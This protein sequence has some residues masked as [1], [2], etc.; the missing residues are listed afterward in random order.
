[1]GPIPEVM[2]ASGFRLRASGL[3]FAAIVALVVSASTVAL[4]QGSSDEPDLAMY[5]RIRDEGMSRSRVMDYAFELMDRIGARLSGSPN[6][7]RAVAWAVDRM[8]QAGLENVR[9]DRWGEFGM[10]WR[11]RGTSVVLI[12]PDSASLPAIAAPW[13]PPTRGPVTGEV[14]YVRGFTDESGFAPLRGTLEGKVVM[15]GR[16]PSLPEV[17]PIDRPLFERFTAAQ[18]AELAQPAAAAPQNDAALEKAFADAAFYE[19][20]SRFFAEEGVRAV[21]TPTGNNARGGLSGGVLGADWNYSLGM[22]AHRREHAMQVP[23]AVV[24]IEAFGRVS[25]L[26]ERKSRVRVTVNVDTEVTGDRVDGVNVFGEIP[27]VDAGRGGDVVMVG[28]HLDSWDVGTGATDDGAGVIIALEA[29][30]ILRALDVRPRRTIRLA[31]WTGEEQGL[32]GSFAW[33]TREI[34]ALPRVDT[35]AQRLRPEAVRRAAGPPAT[36]PAHARLSAYY[37][38]DQGGGKIRGVRLAGNVAMAPIFE[39]WI[40]PLKEL[41]VAVVSPRGGCASDCASFEE[42][43]IP[44]PLFLQDPLDYPS[45]TLHTSADTADHLIP[46]D[47]RQAAVVVATMLYNT[48]MRDD[49][50]PR[51]TR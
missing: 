16:A 9:R 3:V 51:A 13:S 35:P 50:L 39:R 11:Q 36:K 19:R 28:A 40:A 26:L 6:L 41:G 8:G 38:L 17:T 48:A 25:R 24:S 23:V 14:V 5:A 30:R 32:Q 22:R 46:E 43:G 2:M 15:L 4:G 12:E 33:V 18:L 21:L 37:N 20:V 42:A 44:T 49:L 47:L 1:M 34:A 31:L 29:L 27:G 10:G 45:R 7:D